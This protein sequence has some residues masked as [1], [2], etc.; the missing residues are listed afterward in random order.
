MKLSIYTFVKNGLF[1]DFHVAAMLRPTFASIW[2]YGEFIAT[3][4]FVWLFLLA[5]GAPR[6]SLRWRTLQQRLAARGLRLS[7]YGEKLHQRAFALPWP[8]P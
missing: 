4:D 8:E 3:Y 5:S 6:A 7:H 2:P 1:Y